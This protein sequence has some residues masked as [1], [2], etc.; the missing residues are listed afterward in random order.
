MLRSM[1]PL[2]CLGSTLVGCAPYSSRQ[3]FFLMEL[4]DQGAQVQEVVAMTE[5]GSNFPTHQTV[6]MT[7]QRIAEFVEKQ[8]P[9]AAV[10]VSD[11]T[12]TV[13]YGVHQGSCSFRGNELAGTHTMTV[14]Q[15]DASKAVVKHAWDGNGER[16]ATVIVQGSGLERSV[17]YWDN[18]DHS[19]V[20]RPLPTGTG[21]LL[22]EPT[23]GCEEYCGGDFVR[24]EFRWGEPVPQS[25]TYTSWLR[26]TGNGGGVDLTMEFER[27]DETTIE[28][29][30]TANGETKLFHV[31]SDG[32]VEPQ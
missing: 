17:S 21:Y 26:P 18:G 29:A 20:V 24:A 14:V 2:V 23:S 16:E 22:D 1:I 31:S 9:C 3:H 15:N 8:V 28:A 5:L 7:A 11:A 4:V 10:T 27:L 6:D 32:D 25:G 19:W 30:V 12:V 13:K